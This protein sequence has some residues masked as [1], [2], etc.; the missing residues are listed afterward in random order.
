[1]SPSRC[2]ELFGSHFTGT[3]VVA[4]PQFRPFVTD[5]AQGV[6]KTNRL[7][8]GAIG[9]IDD[10]FR[11]Q[12]RGDLADDSTMRCE[13]LVVPVNLL[14]LNL[15]NEFRL[16]GFQQLRLI[17]FDRQQVVAVLVRDLT[18]K[19]L[20]APHRVDAHQQAIKIKRF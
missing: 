8:F 6:D 17:V 4:P 15:V 3:D 16:D 12:Y 13:D 1:M 20:L 18:G 11:G 2:R 10:P 7:A 19:T 9:Q 5:L 14:R